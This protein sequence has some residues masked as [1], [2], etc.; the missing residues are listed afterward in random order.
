MGKKRRVELA[1][2]QDM[3]PTIERT[4]KPDYEW[5]NGKRVK[6]NTI[7]ALER[8]GDISGDAVTAAKWWICDFVFYHEGHLDLL[9]DVLPSGYTKG[10]IH[11]FAIARGHAGERIGMI[12]DRLGGAAHQRLVLMLAQEMSFSKMGELLYPEKGREGR[13]TVSA[14]CSFILEQLTDA[15]SAVR[16]EIREKIDRHKALA[17][18]DSRC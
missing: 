13:R 6:I 11:T 9:K 10:D 18:G 7:L 3:G 16:K 12:Q 17:V 2:P 15:Y 14:Q 5:K 1:V 8:A 4:M